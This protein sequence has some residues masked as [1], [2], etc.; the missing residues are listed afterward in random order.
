MALPQGLPFRSTSSYVTDGAD[1]SVETSTANTTDSAVYAVSYPRTTAQGNT[2]GWE[3]ISGGIYTRN[4]NTAGAKLAGFHF[5]DEAASAQRWR[6]DLPSAGQYAIRLAMGDYSYGSQTC[7]VIIYD[8]TTNVLQVSGVTTTAA[9]R[10]IDASGVERIGVSGWDGNNVAVTRT[11]ASTILRLGWDG[12]KTG[13]KINYLHVAAGAAASSMPP[14]PSLLQRV[15][16]L[17][18]R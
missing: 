8:D 15:P 1:D 2:V 11:F 14:T 13:R 6:M 16:A 3:N 4:R 7:G 10:Y 12:T 18:M 5:P 17:R 9:N